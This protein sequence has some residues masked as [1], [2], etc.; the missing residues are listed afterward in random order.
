HPPLKKLRDAFE[1][2]LCKSEERG[3]RDTNGFS[4]CTVS[5][6]FSED[7]QTTCDQP[8]KTPVKQLRSRQTRQF[9]GIEG[10]RAEET[11]ERQRKRERRIVRRRPSIVSSTAETNRPGPYAL[12]LTPGL[13]GDALPP[14]S[15]V[16]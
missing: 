11:E 3:T 4:R 15:L 5:G 1:A 8:S 14:S 6:W 13:R 10:P 16:C 7:V 12:P 9:G 2:D